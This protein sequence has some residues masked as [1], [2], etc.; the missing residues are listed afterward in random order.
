M[1]NTDVQVRCS[2]S[3]QGGHTENKILGTETECSFAHQEKKWLVSVRE[4]GESF[5][6]EMEFQTALGGWVGIEIGWEDKGSRMGVSAGG[7]I[8]LL[9]E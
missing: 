3:S 7:I 4:L 9:W 1:G 6:K 5:L 8:C 2:Q